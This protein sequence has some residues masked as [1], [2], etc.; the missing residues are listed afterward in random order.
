MR[1]L[2]TK[3]F[4]IESFPSP[5]RPEIPDYV[6]LSHR[7]RDQE[8]TFEDFRE[9]G[10]NLDKL[11]VIEGFDKILNCCEKASSVGFEYVWID[12]CCINKNDQ[13]ELTEALNSM[14]HWYRRAQ[15]CYAYM[16]D[17]PSNEDPLAEGSKFRQSKW[18]TRGWTLQELVAPQYVTFF[19]SDWEEIG[20]KSSFQDLI[21][22]I[23]GIPAQVLL[24]NQA[25]DISVAQRMSWAAKR[26]TAKVED[27]AY[28]LLGLFNLNMTMA[29]G[30]GANAFRR[31]QLEIMKVSDDQTIFAWTGPGK[32]PHETR[33]LLA[34]SPREFE[35]CA[36]VSRYGDSPAFA[37]TNKGINMKL[38]LI[39]QNDET[40][41]GVLSCQ[42]NKEY[43]HPDQYPMGIYLHRPDKRYPTS[44]VRVSPWKT[45]EIREDVS[46]YESK[47]I[48]VRENVRE[49]P[50]RFDVSDWYQPESDYRFFF[51]IKRREHALPEVQH[52]DLDTGSEWVVKK[53]EIS[54]TFP[55]S[56]HNSILVFKSTDHR[57]LA[58]CLGV[59]NYS[60]WGAMDMFPHANIKKI[61]WDYWDGKM[62]MQRWANKDR[63]SLDL[64]KGEVATLA[65]RKGMRD[66][67]RAY[68]IGIDAGQ[69]FWLD[70]LGPGN[71]PGW[72][73]MENDRKADV[74]PVFDDADD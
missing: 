10:G 57:I 60:V 32:G 41:L 47:E 73:D 15:V 50:T 42:R 67:K 20:T 64:G 55:R 53:E 21:T 46:R 18:F 69:N 36:D 40:F 48:Y 71:F 11:K 62:D 74:V 7:W 6:I 38:P 23:T 4:V 33:G 58:I 30:E 66:S 16:S 5:A 13:V 24:T 9:A 1:L 17:V 54:L 70:K 22:G 35:H 29:Y 65:I 34:E 26:E 2:N 28:C 52:T 8:I 45:E 25:R 37:M 68:L 43:S 3:K 44:Y 31:L 12:T 51:T 61:A 56:G 72:W 14:F 49:D 63:L 59:H 27:L 19:G 39:P